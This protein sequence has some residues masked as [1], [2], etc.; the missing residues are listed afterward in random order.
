[1]RMQ[2]GAVVVRHM[3]LG[4]LVAVSVLYMLGG[5]SGHRVFEFVARYARNGALAPMAYA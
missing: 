1:M 3:E 4:S 2:Q 5:S